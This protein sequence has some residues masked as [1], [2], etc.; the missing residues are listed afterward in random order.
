[1]T[2]PCVK[3][4]NAYQPAAYNALGFESTMEDTSL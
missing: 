4:Y 3:A 2:K 1:M